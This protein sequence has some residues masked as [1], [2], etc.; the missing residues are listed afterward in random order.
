MTNKDVSKESTSPK[1]PLEIEIVIQTN[2]N[3]LDDINTTS[4]VSNIT[5]CNTSVATSSHSSSSIGNKRPRNCHNV[6]AY[7]KYKRKYHTRPTFN[8]YGSVCID[9]THESRIGKAEKPHPVQE[10][11][12]SST[13]REKYS[14]TTSAVTVRETVVTKPSPDPIVD[15]Q[16]A[17]AAQLLTALK[18]KGY[19]T[20]EDLSKL[21]KIDIGVPN[22]QDVS[23]LLDEYCPSN[24]ITCLGD[25]P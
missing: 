13:P 9:N 14:S 3:K 24:V 4:A 11:S 10:T 23:T 25:K 5:E 1:L 22:H 8:Q 19:K 15:L 6:N 7:D 2:E 20:M 16:K 12:S 17:S 18:E 21:A